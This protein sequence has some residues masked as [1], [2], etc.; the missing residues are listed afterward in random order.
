MIDFIYVKLIKLIERFGSPRRTRGKET[1]EV[2]KLKNTTRNKVQRTKIEE[3]INLIDRA[4]HETD[5]HMTLPYPS[6]T[7]TMIE[8][9]A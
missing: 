1:E 3:T 5:W 4:L 8:A 6:M 9:K 7:I 2:L